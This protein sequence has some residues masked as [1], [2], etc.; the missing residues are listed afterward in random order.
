MLQ[1]HVK[2]DGWLIRKDLLFNTNDWPIH[3]VVNVRKIV[4]CR[5]LSYSSELIVNWT[6]AQTNPTLV[7]TKIRNWNTTQVSA[8][9][10]TDQYVRV[11]CIRK[12]SYWLLIQKCGIRKRVG[13][14]NFSQSK[15]SHEDK[16]SIPR[17]LKHFTRR[18]LRDIE[19]FIRV[20]NISGSCDH[21]LIKAGDDC[22][23][24]KNV[25]TDNKSLEHIDLG[26][27]DFVVF[28]LFVPE[29]KNV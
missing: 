20:S 8:N 22:L 13:I 14:L 11:S 17:S 25:R 19:F 10:W 2:E 3:W 27:L 9:G 6:M 12:G 26:T 15:S 29:S 1:S 5:S 18:K 16:F 7:G 4:L 23:Y 24:S 28:A 21:L